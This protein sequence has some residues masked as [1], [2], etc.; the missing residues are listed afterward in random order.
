MSKVK[1]QIRIL[2]A[3]RSVL[4]A[5]VERTC[6]PTQALWLARLNAVDRELAD[7]RASL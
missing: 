6:G 4:E 3:K 5:T 7:A 1:R 2:E